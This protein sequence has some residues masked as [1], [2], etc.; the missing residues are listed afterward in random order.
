MSQWDVGNFISGSSALYNFSLYIWKLSVHILL[1]LS[2]KDFEYYLASKWS[3]CNC[4]VF[5]SFCCIVL[6]GD[7]NENTFSSSH[8]FSNSNLQIWELDNKEGWALKNWYSHAV[9]LEKTLDSPL[10]SKEIKPVNSKGNQPWIF[11]GK[12]DAEA[13][14]PILWPHDAKCQHTGTYSDAGK[15]W[16]HEE[17]RAT[18]DEMVGWHHWLD[19]HKFEQ[20]PG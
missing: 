20:T 11:I 3:E 5:W 9:V 12:T 13:E 8:G 1:K 7:C 16:G 17:Q 10:D 14:A 2:L 15:D 6:F 18:E 4:V 19:K